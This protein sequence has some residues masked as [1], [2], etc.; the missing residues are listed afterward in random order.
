M[1]RVRWRRDGL[2]SDWRP[3][4][5]TFVPPLQPEP[6]LGRAVVVAVLGAVGRTCRTTL[7]AA[8]GAAALGAF[9]RTVSAT[10]CAPSYE[11]ST[12]TV[13]I[14]VPPPLR[15]TNRSTHCHLYDRR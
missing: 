10:F 1:L 3:D 11:P 4:P 7:S 12:A 9:Q 8:F 13:L 15:R 14:P 6:P 5:E 2:A